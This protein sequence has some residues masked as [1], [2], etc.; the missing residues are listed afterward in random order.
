[1]KGQKAPTTGFVFF[2]GQQ[3][4]YLSREDGLVARGFGWVLILGV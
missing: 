3:L 1:M 2:S 4:S